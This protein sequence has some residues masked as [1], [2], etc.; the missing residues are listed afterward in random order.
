MADQLVPRAPK[1]K[2]QPTAEVMREQLRLAADEIIRLRSTSD[3]YTRYTRGPD[4]WPGGFLIIDEPLHA[5]WWRRLLGRLR[6]RIGVRGPPY[7]NPNA[8][9]G[10]GYQPVDD[11]EPMNPPGEE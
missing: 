11:G 10:G 1:R 4:P 8:R 6:P 5:P 7:R 3:W 9:P 2:K